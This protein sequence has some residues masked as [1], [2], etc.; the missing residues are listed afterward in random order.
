MDTDIDR[1]GSR[2]S[3]VYASGGIVATSQPLAA[4]AGR[5]P[6]S[7]GGNAVDAAVRRPPR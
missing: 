2:R 1:F 7:A 6:P 3:T 5:E 4:E